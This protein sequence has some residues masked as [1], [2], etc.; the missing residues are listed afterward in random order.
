MKNTKKREKGGEIFLNFL[1]EPR[2]R[3]SEACCQ[4]RGAELAP[5][6]RQGTGAAHSP[7]PRTVRGGGVMNT[8]N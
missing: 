3:F 2:L 5:L 7:L 4:R 8:A 6:A 1:S